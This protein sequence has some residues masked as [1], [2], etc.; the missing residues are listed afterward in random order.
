M[1]ACVYVCARACSQKHNILYSPL[2]ILCVDGVVDEEDI[3]GFGLITGI[4]VTC[5]A[6]FLLLFRSPELE[7]QYSSE[8][9]HFVTTSLIVI[10]IIEN[11]NILMFCSCIHVQSTITIFLLQNA[12]F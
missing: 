10:H 8:Q 7:A 9:H 4:T 5:T 1:R 12:N 3:D 6:G 2:T 11:V